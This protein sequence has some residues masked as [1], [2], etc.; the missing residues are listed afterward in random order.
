M[1]MGVRDSLLPVAALLLALLADIETII[2]LFVIVGQAHFFMAFLYQYKGKKMN[3]RYLG[4]AAVLLLIA[5]AYFV[6]IGL[7][8]PVFLVTSIAFGIH[9]AIDE[10][11]LHGEKNGPHT[12]VSLLGFMLLY[13]SVVLQI[14]GPGY[15]ALPVFAGL[16]VL[17]HVV[18]RTVRKNP[19][20]TTERYLLL[21]GCGVLFLGMG[22]ELWVVVPGIISLLHCFNWTIGYAQRVKDSAPARRSYWKNTL[23][24]LALSVGLYSVWVVTDAPLLA[25]LFV[26]IYW[27]AWAL[28]H[29]VLSS[30][31]VVGTKKA[32]R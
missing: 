4:V 12:F 9:F 15:E 21:V 23:I 6:Y 2:L 14:L 22:L 25:F 24:T 16:F 29:F 30:T 18:V 28:A 32:L 20:S 27:Y 13:G 31:F 19:F 8:V 26:P 11:Y 1:S 5:T 10:F 7:L 17:A 3:R